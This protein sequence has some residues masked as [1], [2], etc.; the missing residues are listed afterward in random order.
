MEIINVDIN[1]SEDISNINECRIC[2]EEVK[3]PKDFCKCKGTQK[4]IHQECLLRWFD[5]E[6]ETVKF[7]LNIKKKCELCNTEI[8]IKIYKKK[9]FYLSLFLFMICYIFF[10]CYIFDILDIKEDLDDGIFYS[11]IFFVIGISYYSILLIF[12]NVCFKN[13]VK[14]LKV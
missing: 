10:I 1:N 3:K 11:I 8:I 5:V 12:L 2:Y 4:N 6:I 7:N 14:F 9:S 13:K